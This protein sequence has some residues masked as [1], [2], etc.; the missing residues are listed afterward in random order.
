[1]SFYDNQNGNQVYTG[2]SSQYSQINYQGAASDYTITKDAHGTITISHPTLGTDTATHI[3]GFWF[4]GEQ[5]WYSLSD[6]IAES[7]GNSGNTHE[8]GTAGVEDVF[9]GV[10]WGDNSY[11]GK[12]PE[13]DQVDYNGAASDYTFTRNT[14]G[15]ISVDKG[16]EGTDTLT[17]IDGFWFR[18]EQ[19]WYS[20]DDLTS[21]GSKPNE[22]P[23]AMSDSVSGEKGDTLEVNV[24]A[25][26]SDPDGDVL[27]V[28]QVAGV[29]IAPGGSVRVDD[30]GLVT[31]KSNG[32]LT[33]EPDAGVENAW[34]DYTVSDGNGKTDTASVDITV[35]EPKHQEVDLSID[36]SFTN[37]VS[38]GGRE[39]KANGAYSF[40]T[41]KFTI[42]VTNHSDTAATGVKVKDIIPENLDVWKDGDS[43]VYSETGQ[44]W[45]SNYWSAWGGR[46]YNGSVETRD[47]TGGTVTVTEADL[48]GAGSKNKNK[49]FSNLDDG[50][51]IWELGT[52]IQP[53]ET[54]TLEY[55]GQRASKWAYEGHTGTGY[56]TDAE[57][58]EVDQWDKNEAND[59]DGVD[60]RWI[61]PIAL[62]LNGDG[63]IGVTGETSSYQKDI[64][65]ELGRTVE[66]D[67][68][69]DGEIDTIEW[70]DGSGDGILVD[71]SKIG[72][73]GS[74]DGSA[75]FGDQGGKYAN[76][77]V[78]LQN[79]DANGD[80][81]IKDAEAANLAVWIDNGDAILQAE[82]LVS[83][84]DAGIA[85]VS[86]ELDIAYDSEGREL[87]QSTATDIDG[88]VILTEDV[89]FARD[90]STSNE[91]DLASLYSE[92]PDYVKHEQP[93]EDMLLVDEFA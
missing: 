1:M 15:T 71:T 62:D 27:S 33:I 78:K 13:Y 70:F 53:G 69:A 28:T 19:K 45:A 30:V 49:Q 50:E 24:L 55:F 5:K 73:D 58:V 92:I 93:V 42:K 75:L 76:G 54:V 43:T 4:H 60:V 91:K 88:N 31:L 29:D 86:T 82:E 74:I 46:P 57:I 89:W 65:A 63:Q 59:V 20:A 16:S 52:P 9:D 90:T 32:K 87:L 23:T 2:S 36:K 81:Q 72:A 37:L 79:L 66:F 44:K 12:G 80:G 47:S 84:A 85:S 77:Y 83:L 8:I 64:D 68:D 3:D 22:A 38:P 48:G 39:G 34:F 40:D 14:D 67:I 6:A 17:D 61:S 10:A 25:N 41:V 35:T 21:S 7:G 26:D 18:G 56:W 11:D 51:L